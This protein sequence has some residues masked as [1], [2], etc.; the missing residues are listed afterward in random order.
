VA[1]QELILT[2]YNRSVIILPCFTLPMRI[3]R[4]DVMS[5]HVL[6]RDLILHASMSLDGNLVRLLVP[7][8]ITLPVSQYLTSTICA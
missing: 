2:T 1:N 8:Y 5:C 6:A 7:K 3:V 4:R